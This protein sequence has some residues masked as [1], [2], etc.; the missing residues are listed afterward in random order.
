MKKYLKRGLKM[1][2]YFF[3]ALI[4]VALLGGTSSAMSILRPFSGGRKIVVP[5][6][7]SESERS[8]RCK[9]KVEINDKGQIIK[10]EEGF[11]L[12]E[13]SKNVKERKMTAKERVLGWL[14]N[15]QGFFFWLV[16]GSIGGVMLGFGGLVGSIWSNLFG[17]AT[18][19][20]KVTVRAI[21]RAKRNGGNILK[22][23]DTAHSEHPKVQKK[24][25]QLRAETDTK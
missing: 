15:F 3:M 12:Q 21:S 25:N 20:L 14:G 1:M 4:G 2:N 18:K 8:I 11:Y 7:K 5:V 13:E 16:I 24:I 23:L 22:E 19:A 9:G 17:V 10:C 6:E